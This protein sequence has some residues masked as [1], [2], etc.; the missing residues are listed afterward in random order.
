MPSKSVRKAVAEIQS[1]FMSA[2]PEVKKR[3]SGQMA[4]LNYHGFYVNYCT[5]EEGI[6]LPHAFRP[7]LLFDYH[8]QFQVVCHTDPTGC[9]IID[10]SREGNCFR[11]AVKDRHHGGCV[12]NHFGRP[13]SS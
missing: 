13:S 11:L 4:L 2:L 8:G 9:G 5:A 12:Y 3:L 6:G 10:Q 1:S 7:E